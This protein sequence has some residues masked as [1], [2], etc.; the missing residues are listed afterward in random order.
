MAPFGALAVTAEHLLFRHFDERTH[1]TTHAPRHQNLPPVSAWL[2][3]LT[4]EQRRNLAGAMVSAFCGA[5]ATSGLVMDADGDTLRIFREDQDA[6]VEFPVTGTN[7][8]RTPGTPMRPALAHALV[9]QHAWQEQRATLTNANGDPLNSHDYDE[10]L[11]EYEMGLPGIYDD[12][13][14]EYTRTLFT[15]A[16]PGQ[17]GNA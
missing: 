7:Y 12:L 5:K 17:G 15:P 10:A 6:P 11:G 8:T 14:S 4:E 2:V 13:I 9:Y 16:V 3:D 1:V